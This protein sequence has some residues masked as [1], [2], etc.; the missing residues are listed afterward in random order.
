VSWQVKSQQIINLMDYLDYID[1]TWYTIK[2]WVS[3]ETLKVVAN[4]SLERLA[5]VPLLEHL[6]VRMQHREWPKK[7]SFGMN[8]PR[9]T[10]KGWRLE[11]FSQVLQHSDTA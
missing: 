6:D 4:S 9:N 5:S 1:A 10:S 8:F 2:P 3:W 11:L 7:E